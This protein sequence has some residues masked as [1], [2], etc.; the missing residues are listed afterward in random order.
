MEL[1]YILSASICV[2]IVSLSGKLATW[3]GVGPIIER[4]LHF[5]VSFA[6]GVL[7]VV[8]YHLSAEIIEHAGSISAGIPWI[9]I[10]AVVVL[11]AFRY[12]PQFHHH[13]DKD[14]HAHSEIDAN[15]VLASDALHNI[16]DGAVI[17]LSFA[18]SPIL[19]LTSTISIAIHEMLQ[20]ISEFF[21]LREA[22]FSVRRALIA[23]FL[24]AATILIGA[25]GAY[26]LV[27]TFQ[28][29]E[30]PL[31]GLA[32]GSYLVVIFNDL[33]P[34]S[35]RHSDNGHH[36]KHVAF[37]VVGL[38]LMALVVSVLPHAEIGH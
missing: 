12:I 21:V 11:I 37:F 19:G 38:V 5:F 28:V 17:A 22:G 14:D 36:F 1:V 34:H 32:V 9:A 10:G 16:G 27:E 15:R 25:I 8:A 26:A 23:N 29:I 13:H 2:M 4:N 7:L 31:L 20:E 35:W 30:I 33:I 18:A 24:T 6:A 3:K